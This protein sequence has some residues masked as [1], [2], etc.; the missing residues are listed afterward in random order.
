MVH[1]FPLRI[2]EDNCIYRPHKFLRLNTLDH[3]LYKK[4]FIIIFDN[5]LHEKFLLFLLQYKNT[6]YMYN[7]WGH[8]IRTCWFA[9]SPVSTYVVPIAIDFSGAPGEI[10]PN[11]RTGC[12]ICSFVVEW[13]YTWFVWYR[14]SI[15]HTS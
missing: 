15:S 8:V 3:T 5:K 2:R 10:F 1:T 11:I 14:T 13:K 9:G 12:V 6:V 4:V 7:T